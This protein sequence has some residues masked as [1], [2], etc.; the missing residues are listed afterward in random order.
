MLV[1]CGR[2]SSTFEATPRN[3]PLPNRQS[4]HYDVNGDREITCPTCGRGFFYY[5]GTDPK[6]QGRWYSD[7]YLTI[8]KS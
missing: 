3:Y 7:C 8:L 4:K 6:H 5:N 2:D 1:K